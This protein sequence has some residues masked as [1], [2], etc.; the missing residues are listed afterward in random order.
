MLE[1]NPR[2]FACLALGLVCAGSCNFLVADVILRVI[3]G[4]SQ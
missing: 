2:S 1:K 4:H 3:A